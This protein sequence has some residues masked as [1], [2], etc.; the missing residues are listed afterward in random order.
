MKKEEQ[1]DSRRWCNGGWSLFSRGS[2]GKT[3]P[4]NVRM[5]VCWLRP[6][7]FILFSAVIYHSQ[8]LWTFMQ[9]AD[10]AVRVRASAS[11]RASR[12]RQIQLR[13]KRCTMR[14][15]QNAGVRM[16]DKSCWEHLMDIA[17]T[18]RARNDVYDKDSPLKR[19]DVS[20]YHKT[21]F[22]PRR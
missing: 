11:T 5:H 22:K 7:L 8:T 17:A 6:C 10:V 21:R 12:I 13:G 2:G 20:P 1:D 3:G 18:T 15:G 9:M 19:S 4:A 14:R 16:R